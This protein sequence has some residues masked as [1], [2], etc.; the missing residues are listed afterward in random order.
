MSGNIARNLT[1]SFNDLNPNL[2]RVLQQYNIGESDWEIMRDLGVKT[3]DENGTLLPDTTPTQELDLNRKQYFTPDI[4]ENAAESPE[5]GL[6]DQKAMRD[7]SMKMRNFFVQEGRT[8]VPEPGAADRAF[9]LQGSQRGTFTRTFSRLLCSS[10]PFQSFTSVS[11]G[12]DMHSKEH[13]IPSETL[14]PCP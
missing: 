3:I 11:S 13:F 9:M 14:Q 5:M 12:L 4:L 1:R 6:G 2:K 8:A 10:D 7:L